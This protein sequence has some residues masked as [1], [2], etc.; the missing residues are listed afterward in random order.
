MET[1]VSDGT[2]PMA[3]ITREQLA[4]MLYRCEGSP[5]VSGNLNAYPDAGEFSD[6]AVDAMVWATEESM[7]N[8]IGGY[9][10]PQSGA[11]RAQLATMLMRFDG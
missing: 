2:N 7:I 10:K 6:W 11:T 9:L 8:G 1:G 5:A 4:A 3:S